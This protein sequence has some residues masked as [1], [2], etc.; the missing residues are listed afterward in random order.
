[1]VLAQVLRI[2][3]L[4]V[5][6]CPQ[7]LPLLPEVAHHNKEHI[8]TKDHH[9]LEILIQM[10][11]ATVLMDKVRASV[12]S[13]IH[14]M[15]NNNK[16]HNL[17]DLK[18]RTLMLRNQIPG[19]CGEEHQSR[20][21]SDHRKIIMV[22]SSRSNLSLISVAKRNLKQLYLKWLAMRLLS[23]TLIPSKDIRM[24]VIVVNTIKVRQINVAHLL[25]KD[26]DTMISRMDMCLHHEEHQRRQEQAQAL[27]VSPMV[28]R[29]A[30]MVFLM[31]RLQI[32]GLQE[33]APCP[34]NHQ[35]AVQ[36]AC[37]LTLHLFAPA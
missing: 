34:F 22:K 8:L 21:I 11:Q 18:C 14:I 36:E 33:L 37:L 28:P 5:E 2:M 10:I 4:L 31:A 6:E 15:I 35:Q 32:P 3:D 27:V 19:D 7:D 29:Q 12:I 30:L 23:Q 25:S 20:S 1:M 13:T 9:Q 24:M 26:M 16:D 17:P